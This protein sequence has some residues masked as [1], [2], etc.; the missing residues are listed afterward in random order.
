[1]E[2]QTP[3]QTE[4]M[5]LLTTGE[6]DVTSLSVFQRQLDHLVRMAAIPG[7]KAHAWARA[8]ELGS[9]PPFLGMELAL[10]EAMREKSGQ[11]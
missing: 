5:G 6:P 10:V 7:F 2:S 3:L 9:S 1:M 8:K 4:L 11:S